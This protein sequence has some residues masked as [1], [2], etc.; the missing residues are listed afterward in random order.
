MTD[1]ECSFVAADISNVS[2]TFSENQS[3]VALNAVLEFV[4]CKNDVCKWT[5]NNEPKYCSEPETGVPIKNE[6]SVKGEF[7]FSLPF[8][9]TFQRSTYIE[10][11]SSNMSAMVNGGVALKIL[12]Q[13]DQTVMNGK[14]KEIVKVDDVYIN[15]FVPFAALFATKGCAISA[16]GN[17]EELQ[18]KLPSCVIT[19]NKPSV[20]L[21]KSNISFRV[22]CDNDMAEYLLGCSVFRWE[23]AACNTIPSTNWSL[24]A[25]DVVDPKAKVQ[26]TAEDLRKKYLDNIAKLL[27]SQG[28]Q[29]KLD[30][31]VGKCPDATEESAA[32]TENTVVSPPQ[33]GDMI[34]PLSLGN[35]AVVF[36][37]SAAGEA[38]I[39]EDIRARTDLWSMTWDH[40]VQG[41]ASEWCFY[42]RT[43]WLKMKLFFQQ[44]QESGT[45]DAV[46]LPVVV[47]KSIGAVAG[48][49]VPCTAS[50]NADLTAMQAPGCTRG[51]ITVRLDAFTENG[52]PYPP[53][54]VVSESTE[55]GEGD[56][57]QVQTTTAA[58]EP[59][60]CDLVLHFSCSRPLVNDNP[61]ESGDAPSEGRLITGN[62]ITSKPVNRDVKEELRDEIVS[63]VRQIAL[64]YVALYPTA[65]A[66]ANNKEPKES[67][68]PQNESASTG[69]GNSSAEIDRK[70][71]FMYYLSSSGV[72]HIMKERLKPRIQRVVRDMYGV[73]GRAKNPSSQFLP[74]EGFEDESDIPIEA[75]LGELYVYLIKETNTVMNEMYESTV[76]KRDMMEIEKPNTIPSKANVVDDENETMIQAF[77]RNLQMAFNAEADERYWVAE[78][79]HLER[80]QMVK[81]YALFQGNTTFAHGAYVEFGHFMQRRSAWTLLLAK[82][83]NS[84]T[85]ALSSTIMSPTRQGGAAVVEST[86]ASMYYEDAQYFTSRARQAL[87]L[88]LKVDPDSYQTSLLLA[89]ILLEAGEYEQAEVVL[90]TMFNRLLGKTASSPTY[91]KSLTGI[92]S[93]DDFDG[94]DTDQLVGNEGHIDP[95]CYTFLAIVFAM[96]NNALAARKAI[97]MAN[98]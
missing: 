86:A 58:I 11:N 31:N 36:N 42:H 87:D 59:P 67:K 76:V 66:N 92:F 3:N 26:P 88:A 14:Q 43:D 90:I 83:C 64:E 23:G 39:E 74:A 82:A 34:P 71:E 6:Q 89:S 7:L 49:N 53:A 73:R 77:E 81:N 32:E 30:I 91:S 78:Q 25:P 22:A 97:L 70:A 2:I 13:T 29:L 44:E 5:S 65:G 35:G 15:I 9:N 52:E 40:C 95:Q 94:Y 75:L 37:T 56:A 12:T 45:G 63:I 55:T 54:A 93:L 57:A 18:M 79:Y 19:S 84:D 72:Y 20:I 17:I 61:T 98:K 51:Q 68:N 27:A 60:I 10:L 69:S 16:E 80:I 85:N 8:K 62:N 48:D 28:D 96:R 41:V 4:E 24:K 21:S 33:I 38:S 1:S 46:L 47:T 50:G